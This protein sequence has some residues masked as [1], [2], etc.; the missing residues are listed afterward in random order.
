MLR[1]NNDKI[2]NLI[3]ELQ[4]SFN[5]LKQFGNLKKE[6]FLSNPDKLDSAK[7]NFIVVIESAIDICN[8]IISQNGFR[9]PKDYGDTFNVLCEQGLLDKN[10]VKKLVAMTK[11]RNRLVHIYWDVDEE[12]V[13]QFLQSDLNDIN[14]F[15]KNIANKL[16]LKKI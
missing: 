10:F 16:K 1:F 11:F 13:Y 4:N 6:E 2:T 7:Y 14:I 3:S 12:Q 8:H 5:R 9:A 15:L